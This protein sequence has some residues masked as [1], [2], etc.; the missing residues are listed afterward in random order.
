MNHSIPTTCTPCADLENFLGG[1]EGGPNLI[2][3]LFCFL[4]D[5]EMEDTNTAINGHHRLASETPLK[6]RFAGGPIM[7]QH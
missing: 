5:K 4:D 2:T 1:G 7:A 6:W 3:F